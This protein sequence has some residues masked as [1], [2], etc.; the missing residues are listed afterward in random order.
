MQ[1]NNFS[2]VNPTERNHFFDNA[3]FAL[4]CLVVMGHFVEPLIK[5]MNTARTLLIFIYTFH[6]PCMF[7]ISGFFAKKHLNK[8][9]ARR[10]KTILT[11][12]CYYIVFQIVFYLFETICLEKNVKPTLVYPRHAMW[13]LLALFFMY[14]ALPLFSSF[15]SKSVLFCLIIALVIGYDNNYNNFLALSR[16]IC[17]NFYFLLGYHFDIETLYNIKKKRWAKLSA[18]LIM[19][20]VLIIMYLNVDVIPL[21]IITMNYGYQNAN[22]HHF[23]SEHL[24][25]INRLLYYVVSLVLGCCFFIL[26][27]KNKTFFTKYGSKTIQVYI[28][29]NFLFYILS[30]WLYHYFESI[31]GLMLLIMLSF[32]FSLVLSTELFSYPFRWLKKLIDKLTYTLD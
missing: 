12:L 4:I 20:I 31:I 6:M 3:K 26:I 1:K 24:M 2:A 5:S 13:Y 15:S 8:S 21:R 18:V 11:Y 22:L 29:H 7:F 23:T 19:G 9:D 16:T 14:A 25:F 32:V 17:F 28:L 27:P 10:S 30:K